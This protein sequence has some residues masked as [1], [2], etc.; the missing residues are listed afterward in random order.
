MAHWYEQAILNARKNPKAQEYHNTTVDLLAA[1]MTPPNPKY[2][3]EHLNVF[4]CSKVSDGG[5]AI[6]VASEEGLKKLNI[7]R[8]NSIE[9]VSMGIAVDPS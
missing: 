7:D 2:F 9:L 5:S 8:K 1:G 6:I 3:V 4:D